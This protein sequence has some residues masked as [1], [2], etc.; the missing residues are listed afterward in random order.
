MK[1]SEELI[2]LRFD[3]VRLVI[4]CKTKGGTFGSKKN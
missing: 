4:F 2:H 1:V 3:C